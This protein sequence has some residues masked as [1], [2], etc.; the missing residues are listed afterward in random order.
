M[1]VRTLTNVL[2]ASVD[3]VPKRQGAAKNERDNFLVR[4]HETVC[5]HQAFNRIVPS[6]AVG[7]SDRSKAFFSLLGF[8]LIK[9][10]MRVDID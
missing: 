7:P 2:V 5:F 4:E 9:P 10:H 3:I 6:H 1:L 8:K